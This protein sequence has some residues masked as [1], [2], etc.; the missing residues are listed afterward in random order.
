MGHSEAKHSKNEPLLHMQ[1]EQHPLRLLVR[2][3]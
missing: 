3:E 1:L 2:I